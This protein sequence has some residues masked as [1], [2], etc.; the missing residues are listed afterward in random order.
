MSAAGYSESTLS[1]RRA[2]LLA[3]AA[4]LAPACSG[5]GAA[6]RGGGTDDAGPDAGPDPDA[7]A[8]DAGDDGTDDDGDGF[9]NVEEAACGADPADP[10]HTCY[11][12][13][14][15]R[16]DPGDLV[17]TGGQVG[18]TVENLVLVDACSEEVPLWDLAG[19]Y[20]ILWMTTA[21]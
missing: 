7:A 15:S 11:A 8:P 14:W 4:L 6:G 10:S 2:R 18:D 16:G 1:I 19:P 21:W 3:L 13:G 12:C 9:T 5:G 20:R 17:A